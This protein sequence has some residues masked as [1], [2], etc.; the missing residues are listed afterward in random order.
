[1]PSKRLKQELEKN[2]LHRQEI[3]SKLL[4]TEPRILD[5]MRGFIDAQEN[6][7]DKPRFLSLVLNGEKLI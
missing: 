2:N 5:E 4:A 6:K 7:K 1:M 3:F